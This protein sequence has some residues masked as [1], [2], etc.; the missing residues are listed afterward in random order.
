MN[1]QTAP[2][3]AALDRFRLEVPS[4]GFAD[5]GTRFGIFRQPAAAVTVAEKLADAGFVP[6]WACGLM[7]VREFLVTAL[8][9]AYER[10]DMSLKTSYLA[11][12]KT[13]TQ[14]QGIGVI[15]LFPV[16]SPTAMRWFLIGGMILPIV[17]EI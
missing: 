5:T 14:M 11:K 4:W 16:L 2:V 15:M 1:D 12:A 3:F 9:S 10:R 8:R 6:G 7:F 17:L 13:W